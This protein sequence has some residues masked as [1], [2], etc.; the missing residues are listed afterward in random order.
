MKRELAKGVGLL[1]LGALLTVGVLYGR[2]LYLDL[3]FLHVARLTF[4]AQQA[5]RAAKPQVGETK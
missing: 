5:Q 3:K 1:L 2:S 4:E